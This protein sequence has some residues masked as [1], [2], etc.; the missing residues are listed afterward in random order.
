MKV[1]NGAAAK[2]Q[3]AK[4]AAAGSGKAV[5]TPATNFRNSL[6]NSVMPVLP[7]CSMLS[8]SLPFLVV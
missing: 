3:K 1:L 4:R 6:Q 8:S 2:E 5:T 7:I